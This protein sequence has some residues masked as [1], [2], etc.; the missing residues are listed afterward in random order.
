M[1][2]AA[3]FSKFASDY[4]NHS[5]R[6][7]GLEASIPHIQVNRIEIETVDLASLENQ[8]FDKWVFL[9][10]GEEIWKLNP[11]LGDWLEKK[12][13]FLEELPLDL[14]SRCQPRVVSSGFEGWVW[15]LSSDFTS[16]RN[17]ELF[18]QS[19]KEFPSLFLCQDAKALEKGAF[20]GE[21][22]FFSPVNPQLHEEIILRSKYVISDSW[23]SCL[24]AKA[25]GKT[26]IKLQTK[27]REVEIPCDDLSRIIELNCLGKT[28][29]EIFE[30]CK[31][32]VKENFSGM[33]NTNSNLL[34]KSCLVEKG[35]L[36]LC[37]VSDFSY[38]PFLLGLIENIEQVSKVLVSFSVLALD[39]AT[40]E[41]L[42][43]HYGNR[44]QV[45]E[46]KEIWNPGELSKIKTRSFGIQA[47]SSK[48]RLLKAVFEKYSVPTFYC[49]SDVYFFECPQK[50]L[51]TFASSHTV[52]F[53]HWND[54]FPRGRN[55]G[56]F[57][58]G[59][60]G[61]R[62][63]AERFLDWWGQQCLNDC[64]LDPSK[65]VV[66][67]QAYLDFAPIYFEGVQIYR[68]G[69]HNTA[70][71][72][73][74]HLGL[75]FSENRLQMKNSAGLK[76]KT[77]HAAFI[78]SFGFFEFKYCWDQLIT[79]F[80]RYPVPRSPVLKRNILV[81]QQ[82]YWLTLSRGLKLR[83]SVASLLGKGTRVRQSVQ[84]SPVWFSG[85]LARL[86]NWGV[87]LRKKVIFIK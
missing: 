31:S 23:E 10:R 58:A 15:C 72:N 1:R 69:D 30:A 20:P 67:D 22:T 59:M 76:V 77:F 17:R 32:I 70:R 16:Q 19:Q 73:I 37:S 51:D 60:I 47:F 71:W 14:V 34:N 25:Y 87:F 18:K 68:A 42:S 74:H 44:V 79:F 57:N 84:E 26:S 66:G 9:G 82:Q 49:D 21:S 41:F 46:L 33:G 63:G 54:D 48:A 83:D 45:F 27:E 50:L 56:L 52:L 29:L 2:V 85:F 28:P 43:A 39:S 61:I 86:L 38:L 64:D 13:I 53:P 62:S 75:S 78:D 35:E 81:Q 11:V 40:K 55:D 4:I 6:L 36:N 65:G 24:L 8:R 7:S 12:S 5:F 3:F 80:C